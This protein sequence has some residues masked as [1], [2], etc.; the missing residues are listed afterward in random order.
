MTRIKKPPEIRTAELLDCAQR[1]FFERGY[2]NT[3]VNDIIAEAGLSKGAFYHYFASK[4]DRE[5]E[6]L[7]RVIRAKGGRKIVWVTLREAPESE[8]SSSTAPALAIPEP[9]ESTGSSRRA[10]CQSGIAVL[11]SRTRT[12]IIT[13][14]VRIATVAKLPRRA[15]S[16]IARMH[17]A[18][19]AQITV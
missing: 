9:T 1:L 16:G 14:A 6:R 8:N 11:A 2:D 5:A 4:F 10:A 12:S 18:K 19:N 13:T 15:R 7:L 17:P 3:T